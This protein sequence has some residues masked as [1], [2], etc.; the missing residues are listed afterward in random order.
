MKALE[1]EHGSLVRGLI[2]RRGPAGA[3]ALTSTL[4]ITVFPVAK[5]P[6]ADGR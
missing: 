5:P 2:A 3:A 6:A 1:R 4:V